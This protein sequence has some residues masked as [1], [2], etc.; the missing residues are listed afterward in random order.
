[1]ISESCGRYVA[2]EAVAVSWLLFGTFFTLLC[3]ALIYSVL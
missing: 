1:M 2:A 3:N